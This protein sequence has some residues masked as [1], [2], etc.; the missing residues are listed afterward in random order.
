MEKSSGQ[1][2][3]GEASRPGPGLAPGP[4]PAPGVP[5]QPPQNPLP[6]AQKLHPLGALHNMVQSLA[7][8]VGGKIYSSVNLHFDNLPPPDPPLTPPL[9]EGTDGA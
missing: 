7:V 6:A 8:P 2:Q 5:L 1:S 4:G 9:S 3:Q